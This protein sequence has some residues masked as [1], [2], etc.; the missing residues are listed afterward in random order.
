M[1]TRL[2]ARAADQ[3]QD[4][5]VSVRFQNLPSRDTQSI[6]KAVDGNHGAALLWYGAQT[7]TE[8]KTLETLVDALK[9][10]VVLVL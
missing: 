6:K 1:M 4:S 9:C 5:H 8:R 7:P 2:R 3:L 10:P